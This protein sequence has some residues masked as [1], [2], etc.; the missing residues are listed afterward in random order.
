VISYDVP[1]GFAK[2][3]VF[4]S[5]DNLI[6]FTKY[7]GFNPEVSMNQA[8]DYGEGSRLD[9]GVDAGYYPSSSVYRLGVNITF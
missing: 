1:V 4:A 7:T 2:I 6:T 5:G 9:S 8:G 3:Q